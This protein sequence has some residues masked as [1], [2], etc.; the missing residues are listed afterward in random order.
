MLRAFDSYL[1]SEV[2]KSLLPNLDQEESFLGRF[3]ICYLPLACLTR[4]VQTITTFFQ[5]CFCRFLTDPNEDFSSVC[6][7]S[8]Q[9]QKIENLETSLGENV[10]GFL[11][12]VATCTYQDSGMIHCPDSQWKHWEELK[13][14]EDNRTG[15]SANL[16][17]FY[18]FDPDSVI[19]R[20]KKLNV[21]SYRFS[22][23]WSQIEK[24]RG[25]Y[26]ANV[27][28][29]Y[30]DFCK[31][32]RDANIRPLV[33]LHHFSEPKE[34]FHDT[35][36]FESEENIASFV[37]FSAYVYEK[38]TQEYK[39]KPL[40]DLFCTINEP[41][42]EAF[43]R[44]IRGAFSPGY[45]FDF[46]GAS[47]FLLKALE[48]H[49]RVYRCLKNIPTI[50]EVKIG[51]THQRLEFQSKNFLLNPITKY[52]THFVNEVTLEYFKSG[53]FSVKVPFF[54]HIHEKNDLPNTD[55]IGLQYYVRPLIGL[56]GSTSYNEKMTLMPFR[57]DPE[58]L[59]EAITEMYE[60]CQ[61][62]IIITENGISTKD[63]EQRHRY[64]ERALYAASRAAK[65]I[66]EEN[67]LGYY[68]WSFCDNGEWD[69]GM[70]PQRFGLYSLENGVLS[71][72]PKKG[73]Y[74]FI[75]SA[76]KQQQN[77]SKIVEEELDLVFV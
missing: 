14:Q 17:S 31:A 37:D 44:Y 73:A 35:G 36:S 70:N 55:F 4:L 8:R 10:D 65:K 42:I 54:C 60:Y 9:W 56:E 41:A 52:L 47:R 2:E 63:D 45:T 68:I 28:Q 59:Y 48:A 72:E 40:V 26:D 15:Q 69:M 12:G 64:I 1:W 61:V 20:L 71:E 27:L 50:D 3:S 11:W 21:N 25:V 39:G 38:L 43:S 34:W 67:L 66:G 75:Q 23:E 16:F 5:S 7:D 77:R 49:K 6:V 18:K 19:D 30:V 76:L 22:V 33:T 74:P 24:Q 51:I 57:E 58:G 29:V 32:L 13:I 46:R 53:I 62:P